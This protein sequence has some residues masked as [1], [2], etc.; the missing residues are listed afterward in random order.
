MPLA[1]IGNEYDKA[2]NEVN[3]A[4]EIEKE[5]QLKESIEF[6]EKAKAS[7]EKKKGTVAKEPN[8]PADYVALAI[9]STVLEERRRQ[10]AQ[11][12][13]EINSMPV[14]S[15]LVHM[16]TLVKQ[17]LAE[18]V[19][20]ARMTPRVLLLFCEVRAWIPTLYFLIKQAYDNGEQTDNE[21][22]YY[23]PGA[24]LESQ[25]FNS[26]APDGGQTRRMSLFNRNTVTAA[27]A[28]T[29]E[30]AVGRS[31]TAADIRPSS[32]VATEEQSQDSS[33]SRAVEP[34]GS[35]GSSISRKVRQSLIQLPSHVHAAATKLIS[36]GTVS[37]DF[38][39]RFE[40]AQKDPTHIRNRLW[41]LLEVPQSSKE[42]R[43]LQLLLVF[44]VVLS[45]F[46]LYTQTVLEL[47]SYGEKYK[48]WR[49]A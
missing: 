35:G 12:E 28:S 26:A 34:S 16:R 18:G 2:W 45:I 44:L 29:L 17:A 48:M 13:K 5:T 40:E 6:V 36:N 27:V 19:R 20:S 1:I 30:K 21:L 39:K 23:F 37:D 7:Q 22:P 42:A 49:V 32:I 14:M 43:I 33:S 38:K 10:A 11:N 46:V 3:T 47:S 25:T 41:I 8:A 24:T 15:S 31:H 4:G 9:S